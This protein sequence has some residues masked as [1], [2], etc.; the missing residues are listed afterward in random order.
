M[1]PEIF[2]YYQAGRE[3][4]RLTRGSLAGPLEFVRTTEL[5]SRF[6]APPP[7][8]V[9]DVGGGPG[10]YASWLTAR[11]DDVELIDPVPLHVEHARERSLAAQI[12]DARELPHADRTFDVVLLMGPLYHLTE[13]A[14]R[15][16]ALGQAFRVL[17][18]G[19]LLIATAISRFAALL[20]LL[21]HLDRL[22]EPGVLGPVADA[23]KTGIFRG[24]ERGLFTTAF[25]H[26]P[27]QLREEVASAGF[28]SCQ[29]LGIE[30]PGFLVNDFDTRWADPAR[31]GVLLQAARLLESESEALGAT[32]HLMA[33]SHAPEADPTQK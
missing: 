3:V 2:A 17:R 9:L 24:H 20:D 18:P 30:G 33:V 21:V 22:H 1:P 12:G 11:G 19:G 6:L 15:A 26:L 8:R 28:P 29:V 16:Q 31:R 27:S 4:D 32:S 10:T 5:I 14:D 7:L 25:F 13:A 23:V